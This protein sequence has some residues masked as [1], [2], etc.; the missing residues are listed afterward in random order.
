MD[1]HLLFQKQK[2]QLKEIF[3]NYKIY[4]IINNYHHNYDNDDYI[5]RF[6][7]KPLYASS[8]MQNTLFHCPFNYH[9]KPM[10]KVLVSFH[11]T[12]KETKAQ[13]NFLKICLVTPVVF[14]PKYITSVE[15]QSASDKP[16]LR[17]ILPYLTST[18][19]CRSFVSTKAV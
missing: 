19:L 4:I 16:R 11:F 6:Q 5:Q 8:L 17:L 18:Y 13:R 7:S 10:R 15:A 3:Y 2:K 14:F 9:S 1:S 12:D